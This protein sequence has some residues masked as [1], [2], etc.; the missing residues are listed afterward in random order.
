MKDFLARLTSRKF[1]LAVAAMVVAFGN[2]YFDWGLDV[3]D[4]L[5]LVASALA[6]IGIEGAADLKRIKAK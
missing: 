6:Y 4:V 5:A 1:I 3:K 2:G